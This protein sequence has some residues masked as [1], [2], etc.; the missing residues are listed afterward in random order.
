MQTKM[1]VNNSL[2]SKEEFFGWRR[3]VN[4]AVAVRATSLLGSK[5][6]AIHGPAML[7]RYGAILRFATVTINR[8]ADCVARRTRRSTS[9][10]IFPNRRS[11]ERE[12]WVITQQE[13]AIFNHTQTPYP[14]VKDTKHWTLVGFEVGFKFL[15]CSYFGGG[16]T[17]GELL[18]ND[19]ELW[20]QVVASSYFPFGTTILSHR[21]GW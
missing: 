8:W 11:C 9:N 13:L 1:K 19:D 20:A 7:F 3:T 10:A 2:F 14:S 16:V 5:K 17:L 15:E 6:Q 21:W 18:N 12:K 4:V